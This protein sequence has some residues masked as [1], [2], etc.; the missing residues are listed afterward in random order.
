MW[1]AAALMLL[2]VSS[3]ASDIVT[4]DPLLELRSINFAVIC[5]LKT[6]DTGLETTSSQNLISGFGHKGVGDEGDD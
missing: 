3:R 4:C 2:I 5:L 6:S 1:I